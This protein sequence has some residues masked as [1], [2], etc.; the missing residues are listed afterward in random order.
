[1]SSTFNIF[2]SYCFWYF[3]F[4]Y[5]Y[6][7]HS[8]I[9]LKLIQIYSIHSIIHFKG[10]LNIC[11]YQHLSQKIKVQ[12]QKKF[13]GSIVQKKGGII[14]HKIT[15]VYRVPNFQTRKEGGR[16]LISRPL[17]MLFKRSGKR[18]RKL[19]KVKRKKAR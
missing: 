18:E 13:Q 16:G 8:P 7:F 1:M 12:Y 14:S 5:Y 17:W 4:W 11:F 2:P 10:R 15:G 6:W 19:K 9:I 3:C